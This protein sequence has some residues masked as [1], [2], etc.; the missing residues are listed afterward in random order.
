MGAPA[1]RSH[2]LAAM[3]PEIHELA[4]RRTGLAPRVDHCEAVRIAAASLTFAAL[5]GGAAC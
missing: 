2:A 5:G 4:I 1:W 3:C